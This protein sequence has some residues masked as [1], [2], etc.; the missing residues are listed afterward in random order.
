MTNMDCKYDPTCMKLCVH[1]S[2]IRLL[3]VTYTVCVFLALRNMG[4]S[5]CNTGDI[6]LQ[7]YVYFWK[8]F[9]VS[10]STHLHLWECEFYGWGMSV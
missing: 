2:M 10:V 4:V 3:Y 8:D 5:L 7:D 6:F 1:M 9:Y